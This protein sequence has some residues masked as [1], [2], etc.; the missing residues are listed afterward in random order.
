VSESGSRTSSYGSVAVILPLLEYL[1]NE[2]FDLKSILDRVG[3]PKAALEDTK[4][5]FPKQKFQALWQVASEATGDPAIA[6]RVSTMVRANA[7]GII[8]YLASAS[9]SRR[10]AFEL[11][12]GLT[13]LLWEDVECD[14]E[15]GGGVAFIRCR[16]GSN[17]QPSHFTTE[18]AVG[19][20][21]TMSRVLGAG[22]S[23][24]LEARFSYSAPAYADEYE[25]I[26][27]LP[28]RFDAGEDGV[29]FPISMM[30]SLNPSADAALRQLLERYAADQLAKIPT[31]ARFSQRVRACILS[32]LP[33]GSLTTDAVAAQFSM[34]S[35]TLRRRL[36]R[37]DTSYQE[38]LDEVRAELARHHLT[39]EKRGID[40]VAFLLGFSDPSSFTKAFRR[41]TGQT[42]A[43]FVR[44]NSS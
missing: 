29:L 28:V 8:G 15:S 37:E 40:E 34:S 13:P 39:K 32:M 19:L 33:L 22:R 43:D 14:L 11:V 42:P 3:I 2:G 44:A 9:E 5:R 4:T 18:Y 25:R 7:L 23:D 41:W 35:R 31:S 16:T 24:P 12:S 26:L 38:I 20:T 17:S 1:E 36:Q 6:L 10:N 30:D 27:R 21:V